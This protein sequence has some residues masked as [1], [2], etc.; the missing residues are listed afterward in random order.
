MWGQSYII[1][2]RHSGN[3]PYLRNASGVT[4]VWLNNVDHSFFQNFLK[5]PTG[6]HSF[7]S[8][9]RNARVAVNML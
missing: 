9:N 4:K 5:I 3:T 2:F 8:G 1:G 7:A 6:E